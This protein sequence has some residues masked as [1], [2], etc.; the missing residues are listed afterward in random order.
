MSPAAL[1]ISRRS[2]LAGTGALVFTY[3]ALGRALAQDAPAAAPQAAS[4]P[5]LPGSL[6]EAPFLDSWI[7]V[8]A[9]GGITVFTGKAELGQGIR[10]A[11]LQIAAEQLDVKFG[12]LKLV[13]A[14]TALTPNEGYTAGSHSLQDSGTAIMHA[15]A[16]VRAIL[17]AAAAARLGV[18]AEQLSTHD[19]AVVAGDGRKL[20]YGELVAD[21]LLH[22]Q[23]QPQ[24]PLK[25]PSS[26]E[27]MGKPIPR[28]DIPA[29]VTGGEAFLQDFRPPDMVHAR[30]VRPPS[31][32]ASLLDLDTSGVETM[33]GVQKVV[34]DGNFI[35]VVAEREFVAI[36]AMRALAAAARWQEKPSLPKQS[37][38]ATVIASLPAQDIVVLDHRP[39]G[40]SA[41]KRL[42]A[43]YTRP[44]QS[45]GSIGPS[46]AVARADDSGVTVWTHT[47]GVFPDRQ[48]IAQMLKL[49][50]AKRSL[51]PGRRLR[52]LRP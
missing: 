25:S 30:V 20:G 35:A 52:L 23:A 15:A 1:Q 9:D 49:P 41:A 8:D 7:R 47:Q 24:S 28:I 42:E 14:D 45:H 31:Y 43:T 10:T 48:A 21:Q 26:F 39:G 36:K 17:V 3:A 19:G 4:A 2:V 40:V 16:Q 6:N 27:V 46:C 37:D 22:V 51:H 32:G 34:R 38:L 33:P 44:Y 13:T 50:L 12:A 29:K 5:K 18:P 11:L